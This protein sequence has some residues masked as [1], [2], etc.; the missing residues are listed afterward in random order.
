MKRVLLWLIRVYQKGISP[1]TPAAC[2]FE[3]TCSH[4]AAEAIGRYGAAR[5]GW[6]TVKRL[7]KCHPFCRACGYDPVPDL[8]PRK[9]KKPRRPRQR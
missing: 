5:G 3:P 9:T 8:D 2:K 7:A 6:L 4:Y 1:Y